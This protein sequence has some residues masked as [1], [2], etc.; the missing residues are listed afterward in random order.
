MTENQTHITIAIP[1][2]DGLLDSHFGGARQFT[3]AEVDRQS[4]A[5]IRSNVVEAPPHQ[6]GLFPAW[7]R[8]QGVGV[9]IV[10]G[11]GQRALSIFAQHGIEVQAGQPGATVESLV[12]AYLDERLIQPQGCGGH[13]HD[14]G[15]EHAHDHGHGRGPCH[16]PAH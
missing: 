6:P 5:M 15:P 3:L 11:I 13:H 16:G 9:V 1:T 7:L 2:A 10:G 4:R 14:H 12:A 8:E